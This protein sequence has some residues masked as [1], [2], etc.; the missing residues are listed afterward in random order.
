MKINSQN[1][2]RQLPYIFLIIALFAHNQILCNKNLKSSNTLNSKIDDPNATPPPSNQNTASSTSAQSNGF[3]VRSAIYVVGEVL[4]KVKIPKENKDLYEKCI[5]ETVKIDADSALKKIW[6]YFSKIDYKNK[7]NIKKDPINTF[8][9]EAMT[10]TNLEIEN[11]KDGQVSK[12]RVNCAKSCKE[13]SVGEINEILQSELRD[14]LQP[15]FQPI[16][17]DV[18]SKNIITAFIGTYR[19][20]D[21]ARKL[22]PRLNLYK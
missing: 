21:T 8:I 6:D 22:I 9:D 20:T 7:E 12:L 17:P 19:N 1:F 2:L 11:E 13:N 15:Y 16:T 5:E 3:N 14:L 18:K 4:K 10:E